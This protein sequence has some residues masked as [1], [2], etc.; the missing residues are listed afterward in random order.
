MDTQTALNYFPLLTDFAPQA[1]SNVLQSH[2]G[3]EQ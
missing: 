1:L 3:Q 2:V